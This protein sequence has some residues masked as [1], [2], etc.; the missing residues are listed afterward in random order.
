MTILH[1]ISLRGMGGRAA[2]A[3]RQARLL[4]LRGHRVLIGCLPG[5]WSEQRARELN[6]TVIADFKFPRGFRPL[7]YYADCRRLAACCNEHG[8]DVVHAHVS[9]ESWVACIGARLARRPPIVIRSRGVV[10]PIKPHLFNRWLHNRL[11]D[12][13]VTPSRVIYDRLCALRGFRADKVSCIPDG[14]DIERFAPGH[15]GAAIRAEFGIAAQLPLVLMVAR[16]EPV[17][18]H[19]IFFAALAELAKQVREQ[20]LP[21]FRALCACDERSPG[22]FAATVAGAKALGL[23][24]PLLQFTGMR[25]DIEQLY[26]AA[27]VIVLPSLG[28]EGSSRVALEAAAA[29]RPVV[30]SSVGCLPEVIQTDR[31]GIVVPPAD[32]TALAGALAKLLPDRER[33]RALG[34]AAR[35]RAEEL[36]DERRMIEKLEAVYSGALN[37][38]APAAPRVA[39]RMP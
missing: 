23:E 5:T 17:K 10:V 18:G 6:L 35:L 9:Q 28:S 31:T 26:A 19:A 12:H 39:E 7:D 13:I 36:Y 2:T 37:A 32:P 16:L 38:R 11:T 24:P 8:V 15:D 4:A 21:D 25:K 20:R 30:A 14:V 33:G 27:D 34:R 1:L 29:A 22:A 3:V